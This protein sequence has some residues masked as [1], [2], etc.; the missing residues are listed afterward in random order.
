[1]GSARLFLGALLLVMGPVRNNQIKLVK[2]IFLS[3][4]SV[5]LISVL[6]SQQLKNFVFLIVTM[7]I[8]DRWSKLSQ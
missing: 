6:L 7:K 1:M 3:S 5:L 2:L 8:T 4:E